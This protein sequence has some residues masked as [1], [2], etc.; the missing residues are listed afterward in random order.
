MM[1]PATTSKGTPQSEI[2]VPTLEKENTMRSVCQ[3]I[4]ECGS[5]RKFEL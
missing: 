3:K 5:V 1:R 4:L 2:S